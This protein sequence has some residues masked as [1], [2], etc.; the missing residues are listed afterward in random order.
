MVIKVAAIHGGENKKHLKKYVL[1]NIMYYLFYRFINLEDK[2]TF[3]KKLT[4]LLVFAFIGMNLSAQE[5]GWTFQPFFGGGGGTATFDSVGNYGIGGYGEFAFLFYDKGLQIGSHVIGRGD[6][7]TIN[8]NDNYGTGS[9]LAKLSFGGILPKDFLRSYTFIQ[10]GVGFGGNNN[11]SANFIFGGGGGIDLF[12]FKSASIYFEA[13]YLQ[14]YI[15]NR[16]IGGV[17]VSIGS[18]GYFNK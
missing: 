9:L 8:S 14:Y 12:W 18:R 13:G 5:N 4:V 10:G 6:S 15:N 7:V 1:K 2:M 11:S 3:C 16:L 17:T